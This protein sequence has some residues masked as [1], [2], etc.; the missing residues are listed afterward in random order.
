MCVCER[1]RE[2]EREREKET[3]WPFLNLAI[4]VLSNEYHASVRM[5]N[6]ETQ[7]TSFDESKKLK[8]IEKEKLNSHVPRLNNNKKIFYLLI[9]T[10]AAWNKKGLLR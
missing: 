1:E 10:E 5:K 7:K 2:R 3:G 8:R 6:A 4:R 9:R